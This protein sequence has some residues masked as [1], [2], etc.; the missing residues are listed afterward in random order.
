MIDNWGGPFLR[1]TENSPDFIS[2]NEKI[3]YISADIGHK[4]SDG[5]GNN[6]LEGWKTEIFNVNFTDIIG[7]RNPLFIDSPH[8]M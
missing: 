1:K 2:K 8:F 6:F 7:L 3:V 4:T 5:N